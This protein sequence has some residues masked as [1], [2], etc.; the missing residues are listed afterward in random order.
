MLRKRYGERGL[1]AWSGMPQ[2]RCSTP[3]H[4]HS[5]MSGARSPRRSTRPTVLLLVTGDSR[6]PVSVRDA[7]D[8]HVVM[9]THRVG[10][11]EA[12]AGAG[13]VQDLMPTVP[14]TARGAAPCDVTRAAARLTVEPRGLLALDRVLHSGH[15]AVLQLARVGRQAVCGR[16]FVPANAC[17]A[18]RTGGGES[19]ADREDQASPQT[20][21]PDAR[22]RRQRQ[23]GRSPR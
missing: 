23:H 17:G 21:A 1:S 13:A 16:R 11:L 20:P 9:G 6:Q 2:G 10:P 12:G 18:R 4:T 19:S 14:R 5:R 15:R 8:E 7:P 22:L 3:R